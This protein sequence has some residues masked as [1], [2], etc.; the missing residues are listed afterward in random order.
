[1]WKGDKL[2]DI[3]R[4]NICEGYKSSDNLY[5]R[6][7]RFLGFDDVIGVFCHLETLH[8]QKMPDFHYFIDQEIQ[9][10]L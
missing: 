8:L 3:Y 5:F 9:I 1:M 7:Y 4:E 10:G 6:F 2:K